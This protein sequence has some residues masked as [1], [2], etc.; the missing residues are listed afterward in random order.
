MDSRYTVARE[1]TAPCNGCKQLYMHYCWVNVNFSQQYCPS[2]RYQRDF[3]PVLGPSNNTGYH[4]EWNG[5][6]TIC[7]LCSQKV[8]CLT[9]HV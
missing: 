2:C 8:K 3:I 6:S 5:R 1:A 9:L 7:D 4:L